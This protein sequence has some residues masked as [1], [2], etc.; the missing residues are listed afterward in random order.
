MKSIEKNCSQEISSGSLQFKIINLFK[1]NRW[2][3]QK[4]SSI[5]KTELNNEWNVNFLPKTKCV[6]KVLR[7]KQYLLRTKWT[8][9]ET[10]I[11]F[12]IRTVKKVSRLKLYLPR[13]KWTI[14]ETL[15]FFKIRR[16]FQCIETEVVFYKKD[17]INKWSCN[18][19]SNMCPTLG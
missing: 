2:C 11:F 1:Y 7:L 15:I 16:I 9:N 3:F 19:F 13:Q 4:V 8:M 14:N 6:Q 5:V 18:F 10:L 17:M 12:K